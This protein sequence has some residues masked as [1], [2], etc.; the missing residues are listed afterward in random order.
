M[1]SR[2]LRPSY[3]A[4]GLRAASRIECSASKVCR[5]VQAVLSN[6]SGNAVQGH[7]GE[8]SYERKWYSGV[9]N[10]GAHSKTQKMT[11]CTTTGRRDDMEID[12]EDFDKELNRAS[13][14]FRSN[15]PKMEEASGQSKETAEK[16]EKLY[17]KGMELINNPETG[18]R[19]QGFAKLKQAVD[20]GHEEAHVRLGQAL[21]QESCLSDLDAG[22]SEF[23]DMF[24]SFDTEDAE[25][26]PNG[27]AQNAAETKE[28]IEALRL[29]NIMK[30]KQ[31]FEQCEK[32]A[33]EKRKEGIDLLLKAARDFRNTDAMVALGDMW[34]SEEGVLHQ[35]ALTEKGLTK[36]DAVRLF[37]SAVKQDPKN[38]HPVAMVNL[39]ILHYFGD[40]VEKDMD[41]CYTLMRTAADMDHVTALLWFAK[42]HFEG[43]DQLASME[44]RDQQVGTQYL[45]R[46]LDKKDAEAQLYAAEIFSL[47]AEP[48]AKE[49]AKTLLDESANQEHAPALLKLGHLH[50]SKE[51][52]WYGNNVDYPK[53]LRYFERAGLQD[54]ADGWYNAGVMHYHGLGVKQS[55]R[56]AF[57]MYQRAAT[58]GS[59]KAIRSIA[60]MM[61]EG[62]EGIPQDKIMAKQMLDMV[63]MF[64]DGDTEAAVEGID[65]V[66]QEHG[67]ASINTEER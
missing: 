18:K 12:E 22:S 9:P 62:V 42:Y 54:D 66:S 46:A 47:E 37:W 31:Q 33:D 17:A 20:L 4:I 23:S 32:T 65:K 1:F 48:E 25:G 39:A 38:P 21:L 29:R 50:L 35:D 43:D 59:I 51:D 41:K 3:G 10:D 44:E 45:I 67:F 28:E 34:F 53:A 63:Q 57:R 40:V 5:D 15:K 13:A 52:T 2:L 11:M 24:P 56:E 7:L 64:E 16:A 60:Q 8:V 49:M 36:R 14:V 6:E 19:D 55:Y 27:G 58:A 26:R 61:Y 30:K